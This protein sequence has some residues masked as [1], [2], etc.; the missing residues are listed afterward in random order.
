MR[1]GVGRTA[2]RHDVR[3]RLQLVEET[4]ERPEPRVVVQ[5]GDGHLRVA[6]PQRGHQLGRG[7]RAA[8]EGEEIGLR[9]RR[10]AAAS[11]SRHSPASHPVVPPSSGWPRRR[12]P[13][14]ATAARRDRPC[15]T[16]GWAARRPGPAAAPARRAAAR[17]AWPGRWRCR[18]RDRRWRRSRPAGACRR[19][20]PNCRGTAADPRQVHQRR[21]DLTELDTSTAD[22]DLVVGAAAEEQALAIQP[23]QVA[24]AVGAPPAQRRHRRVLFGVLVRVEVAGQTDAA[25]HQLADPTD[26]HRLAVLVDD[27]QVPAGQRQADADRPL[28]AQRGRARDDGRLGGAVG[29]PHLAAVDGEP[30]GELRGARLAAED[31]QPHRFERLGGPQRG[32]RRHRRHHGD[33]AGD[34]PRPEIHAAAHQRPRR[35]H[36]AG[37]VPPGQ[38]H[39]LAG[40]V[41]R[42]RQPG[43][44]P[45]AGAD[46]VVL[47][48]RSAPRRRRTR[49]RCDA[50]PRRPW[51]CRSSR[52]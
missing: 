11:T 26:G 1:R 41:E 35:R 6:V 45:V 8:T 46:R 33:V 32:Q 47:A 27:G 52:R 50:S 3:R 21:V 20:P 13:A 25:D 51:A 29:V 22:L 42:D 19:G 39:L 18:S 7:Q 14:V 49:P 30:L 28:A 15:P 31:Q 24:A 12:R 43:Q 23:H 4:G 48:G 17:P 10:P 37:A 9:T 2:P 16:C 5:V 38:P 40:G 44:H 34:Q 36:Q